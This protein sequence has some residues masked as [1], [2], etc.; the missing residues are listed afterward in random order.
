[1]SLDNI[2]GVAGG[3]M[4]AQV[5]RMNLAVSN[6]A[7]AEVAGSSSETLTK[8]SVRYLSPSWLLR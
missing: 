4:D 2:L 1:M 7:N 8:P 3:A 5:I 6:I